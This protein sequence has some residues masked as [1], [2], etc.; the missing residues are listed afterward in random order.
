MLTTLGVSMLVLNGACLVGLGLRGIARREWS[1][2]PLLV[3]TL[4]GV[5]LVV[6][7][8]SVARYVPLGR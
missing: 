6:V 1:L 3:V 2:L 5:L 7:G 4:S 8:C